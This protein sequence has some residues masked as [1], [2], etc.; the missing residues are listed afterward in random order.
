MAS[1]KKISDL[2]TIKSVDG[3][4][5]IPIVKSGNNFK[6]LLSQIKTWM[7]LASTSTSGLMSAADKQKLAGIAEEATANAK[8]AELRDRS[9]HTGTQPASSIENL[10]TVATTGAYSDLTG[11]P[12]L[13]PYLET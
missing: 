1:N 11:L 7:G 2:D 6:L 10:K 4:E 13:S 9:T 5:M 12:D 8:D 3:S